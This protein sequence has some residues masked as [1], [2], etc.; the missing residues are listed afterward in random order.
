MEHD[1]SVSYG[2]LHF[3]LGQ[4]VSLRMRFR[5]KVCCLLGGVFGVMG[6]SPSKFPSSEKEGRNSSMGASGEQMDLKKTGWFRLM[7]KWGSELRTLRGC[8]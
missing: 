1:Y 7:D 2:F 4:Q 8:Y 6:R 5:G 3:L